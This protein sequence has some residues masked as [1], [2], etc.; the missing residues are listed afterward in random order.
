M[1]SHTLS[2]MKDI[3]FKYHKY[4]TLNEFKCQKHK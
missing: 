2:E 3:V 1:K 4:L